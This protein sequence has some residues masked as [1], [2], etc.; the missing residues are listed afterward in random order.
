MTRI[1]PVALAALLAACAVP[2]SAPQDKSANAQTDSQREQS[3]TILNQAVALYQNGDYAAAL[4][5]FRQAAAMG[6]LKAPRYIGLMYLNGTGL[7]KD[8]AQAFAQFQAAA[9]KGDITSQ[10]WLG[11]C[12]ENGSGTAQNYAQAL[13]WYAVSAQ[14][15]DHV[16]APAML[17]L[18]RMHEQ[19]KGVPAS[20]TA[21]AEWYRKAADAGDDKVKTEAR[22]ALAN[23]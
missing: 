9:D 17:A 7:P 20:K 22:E 10:Y 15:G 21:A 14:R 11:W 18:G 12:Y 3:R 23:L 5:L 6:N 16:S 4:P 1:L 19:G 13:R 2:G 8:P